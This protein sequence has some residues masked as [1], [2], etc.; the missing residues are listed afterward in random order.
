MDIFTLD[1]ES[2]NPEEIMLDHTDNTPDI[3]AL[4]GED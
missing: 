3:W 2:V 4:Y 1:L